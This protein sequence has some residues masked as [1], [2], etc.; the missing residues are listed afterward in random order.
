MT[1]DGEHLFTCLLAI[2]ISS[3]VKCPCKYFAIFNWMVLLLNVKSYSLLWLQIF[4]Q[5]HENI[6]S[7]CIA[8][9]FSILTVSFKKQTF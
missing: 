5:I 6:F 2:S 8:C 3:L 1:K 9:L 7:Q 4:Y